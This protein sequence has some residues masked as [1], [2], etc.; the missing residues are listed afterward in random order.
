MSANRY[1]KYKILVLVYILIISKYF[2][3]AVL[4]LHLFHKLQQN[5][6]SG[7]IFY[8]FNQYK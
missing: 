5:Y 3:V 7:E 6:L 2:H 4:L 8:C 1:L